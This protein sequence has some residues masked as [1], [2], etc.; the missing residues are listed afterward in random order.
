MSFGLVSTTSN[1]KR[2]LLVL[3]L[4]IIRLNNCLKDMLSEDMV[5]RVGRDTHHQV[6][7]Y[8]AEHNRQ[9]ERS[10]APRF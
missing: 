7:W 4:R 9:R 8:Q 2:I 10:L 6:T 5:M 1:R 3:L